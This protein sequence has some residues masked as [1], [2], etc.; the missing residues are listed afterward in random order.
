MRV[1]GLPP[2][3]V[4]L[5]HRSYVLPE[6]RLPRA[7]IEVRNAKKP[8]IAFN[9]L[10]ESR[11]V[12]AKRSVEIITPRVSVS[13]PVPPGQS[14]ANSRDCP[15]TALRPIAWVETV[16]CSNRNQ[17]SKLPESRLHCEVIEIR[18]IVL[19]ESRLHRA[20]IEI[21]QP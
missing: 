1:N 20:V 6:S 14:F 9:S 11:D 19:T 18:M 5:V 21:R 16:S 4:S 7:V 10:Q 17:A 15:R 8:T 12:V 13:T 3:V 2:A